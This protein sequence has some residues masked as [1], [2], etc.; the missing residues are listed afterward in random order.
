MHA[1]YY[2]NL[3]CISFLL[4]SFKKISLI[5]NKNITVIALVFIL[6]NDAQALNRL[7]GTNIL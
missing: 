5:M 2:Y 7:L 6:L 1:K 4:D 3:N